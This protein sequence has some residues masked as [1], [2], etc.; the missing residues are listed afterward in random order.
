MALDARI[1][2]RTFARID[3]NPAISSRYWSKLFDTYQI[4]LNFDGELF[5]LGE[6]FEA[7]IDAGF[8]WKNED[9]S[10]ICLNTSKGRAGWLRLIRVVPDDLKIE[11]F[12]A[13]TIEGSR[14]EFVQCQWSSLFFIR[15]VNSK[16]EF[17][18]QVVDADKPAY[19]K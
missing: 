9:C 5:G 4:G 15:D 3:R 18:D 10:E 1:H 6:R 13:W 16:W 12:E 11:P 17:P 8:E 19:Q 7:L 2:Y 14:C